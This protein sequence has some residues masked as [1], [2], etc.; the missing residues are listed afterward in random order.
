M[1]L[2]RWGPPKEL[3][4]LLQKSFGLDTFIE[5]GTYEGE[6]AAWAAESFSKV[7]TIEYSEE[8]YRLAQERHQDKTNID[9]VF[10]N[11]AEKLRSLTEL[12]NGTAVIWLDGHWSGGSTYGEYDECP[13]LRELEQLSRISRS[14][15][16]LIDD[17]RLFLSPP[18]VPHNAD[19]WP[20]IDKVLQCIASINDQYYVTVFEDV[21]VCVPPYAKELLV[22][23]LQGAN[24]QEWN[25]L[26]LYRQS[27]Q[28]LIE[29]NNETAAELWH[30]F[31]FAYPYLSQLRCT[32][33]ALQERCKQLELALDQSKQDLCG[34]TGVMNFIRTKIFGK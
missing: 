34:T 25:T 11:S 33:E 12:S 17:A 26:C 1:G 20:T 14:H 24:T 29:D 2:V 18:P 30:Q 22:E 9:F 21:I 7:V 31:R 6:T 19:Q 32:I 16:L 23:Y 13:L 8:L 5:T 10:G 27:A 15:F 3:I 28:Q 4:L